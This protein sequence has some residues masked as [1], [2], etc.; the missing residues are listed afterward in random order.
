MQRGLKEPVH[1]LDWDSDIF[2]PI[3]EDIIRGLGADC[4]VNYRQL[5]EAHRKTSEKMTERGYNVKGRTM[6]CTMFYT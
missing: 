4:P 3:S 5:D 6:F 2:F 1:M